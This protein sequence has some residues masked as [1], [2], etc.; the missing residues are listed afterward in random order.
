[1]T[2]S[3]IGKD[4]KN[5]QGDGP[6]REVIKKIRRRIEDVLRKSDQNTLLK[7]AQM[8]GVKTI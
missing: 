6:D 4:V 3:I 2:D 7:V 1:M 8:L 5:M